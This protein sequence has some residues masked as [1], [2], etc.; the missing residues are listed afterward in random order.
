MSLDQAHLLPGCTTMTD[1]RKRLE[2]DLRSELH[3]PNLQIMHV[4]AG[5]IDIRCFTFSPRDVLL[6]CAEK[7]MRLQVLDQTQTVK[8][9]LPVQGQQ[10]EYSASA[11]LRHLVDLCFPPQQNKSLPA[12]QTK[13]Q[14]ADAP[15][16]RAKV[17]DDIELLLEKCKI[18]SYSRCDS[19][20]DSQDGS[21]ILPALY[22]NWYESHEKYIGILVSDVYTQIASPIVPCCTVLDNNDPRFSQKLCKFLAKYC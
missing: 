18:S 4:G 3:D 6:H 13:P 7:D 11:E 8:V 10:L 19:T 14:I 9:S 17:A 22:L 12:S 1:L 20:M 5:S 16:D 21:E 2:L 15:R